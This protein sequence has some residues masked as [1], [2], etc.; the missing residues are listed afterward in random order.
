VEVPTP[1]PGRDDHDH[2]SGK[3]Y[4][5]ATVEFE[6]AG[7][8][9]LVVRPQDIVPAAVDRPSVAA[10]P[11]DEWLE[12]DVEP[13]QEMIEENRNPLA[14]GSDVVQQRCPRHAVR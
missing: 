1:Q 3:A 2:A 4:A 14:R 10:I 9:E 6:D 13:V 7:A 12:G 5:D 11:R 8:A